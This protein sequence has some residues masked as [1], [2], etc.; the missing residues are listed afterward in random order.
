MRIVHISDF[1]ISIEKLSDVQPILMRALVK[2]LINYNKEEKIDL[3]AYTG[4]LI[5]KGGKGFNN[6]SEAFNKFEEIVINPLLYNLGLP[7]SNFIFIPGNHDVERNADDPYEEFGIKKKLI[8]NPEINDFIISR[9]KETET[10]GIKRI[11]PFKNFERKFHEENN[12]GIT[13]F[14]STYIVNIEGRKIGIAGF[15]TAWRCY[16]EDEKVLLGIQQIYNAKNDLQDCDVKIALMHH[17]M[18]YLEPYER[19][20]VIPYISREFDLLLSG[21]VHSGSSYNSTSIYGELFVSVAPLITASNMLNNDQRYMNGYSII[22][23]SH[24][25]NSFKLISRKYAHLHDMFISNID[26]APLNGEYTYYKNKKNGVNSNLDAQNVTEYSIKQNGN[27]KIELQAYND[28]NN[29]LISNFFTDSI[30]KSIQIKND[31]TNYLLSNYM[32]LL[33]KSLIE[34]F[35]SDSYT[36]KIINNLDVTFYVIDRL[37]IKFNVINN[38]E[39]YGILKQF[40]KHILEVLSKGENKED[41][42]IKLF[43]MVNWWVKKLMQI[44]NINSSQENFE[45]A[46]NEIFGIS[47]YDSNSLISALIEN[48]NES[49]KFIGEKNLLKMSLKAETTLINEIIISLFLPV[50][51]RIEVFQ[52]LC[53][54]L[55]L[56]K[57]EFEGIDLIIQEIY[58]EFSQLN[59][60]FVGLRKEYLSKVNNAIDNYNFTIINGNKKT[61]KTSLISDYLGNYVIADSKPP[62][63]LFFSFKVTMNLVEMVKVIIA[64]CNVNI[65]NQIDLSYLDEEIINEDKMEQNNNN[66]AKYQLIKPF[67]LEALNRLVKECGNIVLILDSLELMDS[68]SEKV[69]YIIQDVPIGC[70]YILIT[71]PEN[72]CVDWIISNN[73][74]KKE[75]INLKPLMRSEIPFISN[76]RDENQE[77]INKNDIIF[78]KT[79]GNLQLIS[80]LLDSSS[81]DG[82]LDFEKL[83]NFEE[84]NDYQNELDKFCSSPVLE[85]I[86]LL[87]SLFE[88]I[89]PIQLEYVQLFLL[90]RNFQLRMPKIKNELR[91]VN[92]YISD[93][94]FNRIKLVNKNLALFTLGKYYSQRDVEDFVESVFNWFVNDD[95][96]KVDFICRFLIYIKENT[97]FSHKRKEIYLLNFLENLNSASKIY[98]LGANLYY[99]SDSNIEL[100]LQFLNKAV[101]LGDSNAKVLLGYIYYEGEK[102]SKNN[103]KA[104]ELLRSASDAGNVKAKL[105]LSNLLFEG[106]DIERDMKTAKLLLEEAVSLGSKQAKFRLAIRLLLGKQIKIDIE[107]GYRLFEELIEIDYLE[108]QRV[109]GNILLS[110]SQSPKAKKGELLLRKAIEKGSKIAKL[111]LARFYISNSQEDSIIAE[112]IKLLTE[113]ES[114]NYV[115]SI[116]YYSFILING[117]GV[118]KDVSK[119]VSLLEKLV[120]EGDEDSLLEYSKLMI[121]GKVIPQNIVKAIENLENLADKNNEKAICYLGDI[122]IEGEYIEKDISRG[123]DLLVTSGRK[124]DII[125]KRKLGYRYLY[126]FGLDKNPVEGEKYLKEAIDAG[127]LH[128]KYLYANSIIHQKIQTQVEKDLALELLE[129]SEQA[130]NTGAM[131][132]LGELYL[133]GEFL[134]KNIEKGLKYFNEAIDKGDPRAMSELGHRLIYGIDVVQDII[135][136]EGLLRRAIQLGDNYA[137]TIYSSAIIFEEINGHELSEGFELLEEVAEEDPSAMRILGNVLLRGMHGRKDK[138]RGISLLYGSMKKNDEI[139]T[140]QLSRMLFEGNYVEKDEEKGASILLSLVNK[141]YEESTLEYAKRLIDG[142][143]FDKNIKKGIEVLE[144]L[145]QKNNPDAKFEYAKVLINGGEGI[146]KNTEKGERILREAVEQKH[147]ESIRLLAEY[148][149]DK[150]VNESEENEA[151]KLLNESI[152][153]EDGDQ[154]SAEYLA[155]LFS[156][157]KYVEK[158]VDRAI[159]LYEKSVH[160]RI[161]ECGVRYGLKLLS[162]LGINKDTQKGIN[163]IKQASIRGSSLAKYELSRLLLDGY[164]IDKD[165]N[166][167]LDI[168]NELVEEGDI[169]A[170]MFLASILT[171]GHRTNRDPDGAIIL[172]EELVQ[173]EYGPGIEL[174]GELLLEGKYLPRDAHKG[175]KLLKQ[176]SQQSVDVS[177]NLGLKYLNGDGV[178]KHISNGRDRVSRAAHSENF[179]A[180]FELGLRLKRGDKFPKNT[181][182]GQEYIDKSLKDVTG[183]NYH[184]LALIAYRLKDYELATKFFLIAYENSSIDA[185]TSLAYMTRRK[186]IRGEVKKIPS[187]FMLLEK[188]L[189]NNSVTAILNLVLSYV[190]LDDDLDIYWE[191]ADNI[192]RRLDDCNMEIKWWYDIAQ[193][194]DVEGHLIVGWLSKYN[195]IN[196]VFDI[197]YRERFNLVRKSGVKVPD[198]M[199]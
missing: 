73:E 42:I 141:G 38:D 64:L 9:H 160:G 116:R 145:V 126:G 195:L 32:E 112:G 43:A 122:F 147:K 4:D 110:N 198:W 27:D 71:G 59:K 103:V 131:C 35:N 58:N 185:G 29:I 33:R 52:E 157:G 78:S 155:D 196:D 85:E 111:D 152:F 128:A 193:E 25:E 49:F 10:K 136:G 47:F 63:F 176:V 94:R 180:M 39:I 108:A 121:K 92:N 18:D 81:R 181:K 158:D 146:V 125:S 21:H 102:I 130:G 91:L 46:L 175:E 159:E 6:I 14:Q 98:D 115:D 37:L 20:V 77:N 45:K 189:V 177:Y 174:Y 151:V 12:K 114:D 164:F 56:K 97:I 89:Q 163:L 67:F 132:S 171:Y 30:P 150:V 154:L 144:E 187:I 65:V 72:E 57:K 165:V 137:K 55:E 17:Q 23:Y 153:T 69:K 96:I 90:S 87:I 28:P 173:V 82:V 61:G 51:I 184:G 143:G 120:N 84:V 119:G 34:I 109:M 134:P 133:E 41:S 191:I 62:L 44:L 60:P 3:I 101:D 124:G 76:L 26:I 148:I 167:G 66:L 79:E 139:T 53:V 86:L 166:K 140:L 172:F 186:E 135:K 118:N 105:T 197:S 188:A 13:N 8:N 40:E 16:H 11:V 149:V 127:D 1:H 161:L 93:L 24:N 117:I 129:Q 107:R 83:E 88:P 15:N 99:E 104:I 7:K 36:K 182:K 50:S 169:S 2:D 100:S 192:I 168:L 75:V 156:E 113:L 123:V 54:G 106:R 194:N 31:T 138:T 190:I 80:R 5:D 178:K 142:A 162:G 22:D 183:D 95:I 179:R 74:L 68:Q 199:Y 70:H 48:V 170:K 19:E